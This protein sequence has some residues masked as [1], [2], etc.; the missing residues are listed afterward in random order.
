MPNRPS[1]ICSKCKQRASKY[2]SGVCAICGQ[3]LAARK[4]FEKVVC[5][6][7]TPWK[8]NQ[9]LFDLYVASRSRGKICFEQFA[10]TRRLADIL[11]K[12]QIPSFISWFDVYEFSEKVG[13]GKT[14]GNPRKK[15]PF[16]LIGR[17]LQSQGLLE[18]I[19]KGYPMYLCYRVVDPGCRE[20]VRKYMNEILR[21]SHWPEVVLFRL[22]VIRDFAL[23]L[24]SDLLMVTPNQTRGYLLEEATRFEAVAFGNRRAILCRFYQW[25]VSRKLC[26][27]NPFESLDL[28]VL[29]KT[30]PRCKKQKLIP[31]AGTHCR[32]CAN[33]EFCTN[34]IV[35]LRSRLERGPEYHRYL[36]DLYLIY[37]SRY[38]VTHNSATES[39][40]LVD[41]FTSVEIAPLLSWTDVNSAAK[42][43][44]ESIGN[45]LIRSGCPFAKIGRMLV[46]LRCIPER[47]LDEDSQLD[48]VLKRLS[49][50][51]CEVATEYARAM[52]KSGRRASSAHQV[53]LRLLYFENWLRKNHPN[54]S[55][56][57]TN[58]KI[59][60]DFLRQVR[61]G[62]R[63]SHHGTLRRFHR[64]CIHRQICHQN[65]FESIA[66]A[67]PLHELSICS[68]EQIGDLLKF[69]K[70]PASD[71]SHAMM[72][73][74]SLFWAF[75][76]RELR[77]STFD[78]ESD[79]IKIHVFQSAL[80][81]AHKWP[82]RADVFTVPRN[83]NWLFALQKRFLSQWTERFAHLDWTNRRKLLF[84]PPSGKYNR[85]TSRIIFSE[86][87]AKATNA[88]TG[89]PIPAKAL[90]RTA[91]HLH[92]SGADASLLTQLGWAD[93]SAFRYT[94]VP[95]K[96]IS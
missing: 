12:Q 8:Y 43:Y 15:C 94:W 87:I 37:I 46:E 26:S 93:A 51:L 54:T 31:D 77:F 62:S 7:R 39:K 6:F 20:Y 50:A 84:P 27:V 66:R 83:P 70:D 75:G 22:S 59:A 30:C 79:T 16:V 44:R 24:K 85:P 67:E 14:P 9:Y 41:L 19:P 71:P 36:Y 86:Q 56:F 90:R 1:P 35:G 11:A 72:I 65:P 34:Y 53:T 29:L 58:S 13:L 17:I 91:G 52:I 60:S 61:S 82:T 69:V 5:N 88:A 38:R 18:K 55:F 2:K 81:Y 68:Q 32:M 47:T 33:D 64:W 40:K 48:H 45:K 28:S 78:V 63:D 73:T 10:A 23:W 89:I 21:P 49:P 74:L 57:E 76:S 3:A 96:F 92:V 95:R 25:A 80:S 4:G 42:I